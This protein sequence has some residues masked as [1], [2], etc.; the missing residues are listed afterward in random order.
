MNR[1]YNINIESEAPLATPSEIHGELPIS[2]EAED[3]VEKSRGILIDILNHRDPRF[4]VITGPCSISDIES[5]REYAERLLAL[6]RKV[7]DRIFLIM[8]TYFEKPRT[9][10][11]WKG[12]IY[13]PCMDKSFQIERGL[14]LSRKFLLDVTEMGLPAATEFLDPIIP[15]YLSDLITWA[16]IGARTTE[17]QTHRQMAS[18]MSMP[19]GFKNATD[20]SIAIAIDAIKTAAARH[21]FLGV[22]N[23]GRTGIFSTRG[24]PNCHIV[25]RGS[26]IDPNYGSEYVAFARELLRKS[27]LNQSILVDC[28]HGN[29]RKQPKNQIK[30]AMDVL[31]QRCGGNDSVKG[32][33][34]ESYLKEG[35]QDISCDMVPGLSVTDAC[36]G[37]EDTEELILTAHK[38]LGKK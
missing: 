11:G 10:V 8:R 13:D 21:S 4:V 22:T 23:D 20:G 35:R 33:M 28:S 26:T 34:L 18:G 6:Q 32:I 17:S 1:V 9:T 24:N 36:L 25:L 16:A 27:G 29:S 15:Q 5:A 30:A 12:L 38:M 7:S 2:P 19:I 14:R 3:F 31:E 37:W